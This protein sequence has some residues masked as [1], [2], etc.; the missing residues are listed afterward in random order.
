MTIQPA[1]CTSGEIV[2]VSIFNSLENSAARGKRRPA[3]LLYRC[4][5]HWM[6][7][8]LTSNPHFR[9]GTPRVAIPS[10]EH[11]GLK[12]SGYLWGDRATRV[13]A[14]DLGDHIGWVDQQL[15][16][17]IISHAKLYGY[18]ADVLREVADRFHPLPPA[19]GV[20]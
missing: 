15:A 6:T 1:Y 5:G 10:P 4:D 14:L 20:A 18:V 3:V 17:R 2:W 19:T 9:D 7:M 11:V 16:E 12:G 8:G 13:S